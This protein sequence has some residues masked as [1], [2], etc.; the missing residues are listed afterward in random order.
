MGAYCF[1]GRILAGAR[2][3]GP[4]CVPSQ[5]SVAWATATPKPCPLLRSAAGRACLRR[6]V[7][8]TFKSCTDLK[9]LPTIRL[10]YRVTHR[11]TGHDQIIIGTRG[12]DLRGDWDIGQE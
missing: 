3:L 7:G 5:A 9:Y 10:G 11:L 12:C 1:D 6:P 4:L 8:D 2:G